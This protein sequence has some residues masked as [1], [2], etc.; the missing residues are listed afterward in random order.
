MRL[1]GLQTEFISVERIVELIET[2]QEPKG[3]LYPPAS[4]PQLGSE[5]VFANVTVRYAPHLDPSLNDIS[6]HIPG[7]STTAILGRTGSGKSTLASAILNIV[8]AETGNITID[9]VSLTNIDVHTLRRRITY[10]PQDPVLFLGPIRQNLDPVNEF[11]DEECEAILTRVCSRQGWNLETEVESGGKN[12]SLGQRQLIGIARAVLRR[13]P[14]VILDE[15]TA[16]IDI[17]TSIELQNILREE[18]KEAT[19]IVIAH[20]VEAVQG[21]DYCVVLQNGRVLRQGEVNVENENDQ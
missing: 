17:A 21:A 3:T 6:L 10:V 1:A 7:G 18:L 13:S 14:I 19:I 2:E 11:T 4:W 20:R 15:A 8:R 16:S 12:L 5:V 9:N